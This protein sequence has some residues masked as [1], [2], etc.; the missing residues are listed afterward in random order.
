MK[1]LKWSHSAKPRTSIPFLAKQNTKI[2]FKIWSQNANLNFFW[3]VS[4]F[5]VKVKLLFRHLVYSSTQPFL[6]EFLTIPFWLCRFSKIMYLTRIPLTFDRLLFLKEVWGYLKW[7]LEYWTKRC[8]TLLSSTPHDHVA[9]FF[10]AVN[11]F[12]RS[13]PKSSCKCF[14]NINMQTWRLASSR[15][16]LKL[17]LQFFY[18]K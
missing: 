9:D 1:Y 5:Q 7:Y 14:E 6:A 3:S 8:S 10:L 17:N 13:A 2:S 4:V 16:R 18:W 15:D 12:F 11:N